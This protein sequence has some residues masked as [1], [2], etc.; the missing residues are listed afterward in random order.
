MRKYLERL[1]RYDEN[2]SEV[3]IFEGTRKDQNKI[4]ILS[5]VAGGQVFLSKL[6]FER[7]WRAVW[8]NHCLLN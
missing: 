4:L 8:I 6:F 5:G 7:G 3:C 2:L 1:Q